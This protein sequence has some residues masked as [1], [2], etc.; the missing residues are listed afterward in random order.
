MAWG[1]RLASRRAFCFLSIAAGPLLAAA[2]VSDRRQLGVLLFDGPLIWAKIVEELRTALAGLGW[3]EGV[4]LDIQWSYAEGDATR[5]PTLA[6]ALVRSGAN[7]VMTR[8]TPATRALQQATKTV[9]IVTGVGDPIGHGFAASLAAPGGN[10]TGLSWAEVEVSTKRVELLRELMP[11]LEDLTIVFPSRLRDLAADATRAPA[12]AAKRS[13]IKTRVVLVGSI[14]ELR[15]ALRGA[16]SGQ[17]HAAYLFGIA[18]IAPSV[19]ADSALQAGTATMFPDRLF[20]DGGGLISY[21]L[22]W[23]DQTLRT[24][25]QIDKLLRGADPARMPFELPTHADLALNSRTAK[26]LGIHVPQALMIRADKIFQ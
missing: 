3:R 6:A 24:A 22:D 2:P 9:P 1:I 17:R 5:L 12:L 19:I 25:V 21:R 18:D 23:V 15:G 13:G 4:N 16:S 14:A 26:T 7:V 11:R 20:V 10:I 8:G